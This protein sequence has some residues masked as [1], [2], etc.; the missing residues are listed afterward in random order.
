VARKGGVLAVLVVIVTFLACGPACGTFAV[1]GSV[2]RVVGNVCTPTANNPD[3]LCYQ[4]LPT[5]G[6]PFPYLYDSPDTS[7]LGKLGLE[8]EFKPRW[9]LVDAAIFGALPAAAAVAFLL[10]W[11]RR[12]RP[13][14]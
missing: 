5:A 13:Q 2:V 6:W 4:R 1:R 14:A 12:I 11:W 10:L 7:V 8:D 9:F 3:G